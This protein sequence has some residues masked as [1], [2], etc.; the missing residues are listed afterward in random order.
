MQ[1]N[2]EEKIYH[3]TFPITK[4]LMK[5]DSKRE[6]IYWKSHW[7]K[8]KCQKGCTDLKKKCLVRKKR[9]PVRK[10]HGPVHKKHG[11]VR[12]KHGP[13]HKKHGPVHKKHG[14]VHKKYEMQHFAYKKT[15]TK[16]FLTFDQKEKKSMLKSEYDSGKNV[17][18]IGFRPFNS[19]IRWYP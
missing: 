7:I 10:K 3:P 12:K 8:K 2:C 11:P 15:I 5:N 16:P 19:N 13:V 18:F 9:G 17:R 14:P 1:K 4:N 6:V